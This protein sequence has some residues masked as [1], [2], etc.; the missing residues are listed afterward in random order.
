MTPLTALTGYTGQE[1]LEACERARE[2]CEQIGDAPQLFVALQHLSV[3]YAMRGQFRTALDLARRCQG[4]AEQTGDP[5]TVGI[6]HH[7]LGYLSACIAE[8][9]A[10]R[11]HLEHMIAFYDPNEHQAMKYFMGLD[12]GAASRSWAA[13]VLWVLGYPDQ[14]RALRAEA[15]ALARRIDHPVSLALCLVIAYSFLVPLDRDPEMAAERADE[16][17]RISTEARLPYYRANGLFLCAYVDSL[18]GDVEEGIEAMRSSE[19]AFI[20]IGVE[21]GRSER[22]LLLA[23]AY[24]RAGRSAEGLEV[25]AETLPYIEKSGEHK[26]ESELLRLEGELRLKADQPESEAERSF[27]RAIDVARRQEARILELRAT[28][29]LARLWKEQGRTRE[30]I[31]SLS[32]IYGWFTEGFDT[33]DLEDARGLL[34]ELGT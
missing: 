19:K 30:A 3:F 11:T 8:Y 4:L 15:L 28:T 20:A 1:V 33:P 5:V 14:A 32:D 9:V 10:A 22:C 2:L 17:M 26:W 7:V 21:A 12:P 25:L 18:L 29:S 27:L 31:K 13:L 24:G 34:D 6:G 16:L 23:E